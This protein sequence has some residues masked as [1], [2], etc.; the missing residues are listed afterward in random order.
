MR[1]VSLL[2]VFCVAI[3]AFLCVRPVV[4]AD[5]LDAE[6]M[7]AALHTATPQEEGFISGVLAKVSA[8]MLPYEMVQSTFLWAKQKP[9][10]RRF[11]YFKQG[12][13]LRAKQ[14]GVTL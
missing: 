14:I 9:S 3:A 4:A 12:L 13:T 1:R 8:G 11:F 2:V 10:H 5:I 6:T 7:K